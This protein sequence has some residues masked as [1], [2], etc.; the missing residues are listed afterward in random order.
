MDQMTVVV[1]ADP[2]PGW[3]VVAAAVAGVL[4]LIG[5]RVGKRWER[6]SSKRD[7]FRDHRR[8]AYSEFL[9]HTLALMQVAN[10]IGRGSK[11]GETELRRA[12]IMD[13]LKLLDQGR[14]VIGI[15]GEKS[16]AELAERLFEAAGAVR[17]MRVA[18]GFYAELM[19]TPEG[20]AIQAAVD[21]FKQEARRVLES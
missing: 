12:A 4:A 1:A 21:H 16:M 8:V 18:E 9:Q 5:V 19:G 10:L 6:D 11:A 13:E 3:P 14:A 20:E 7:W 2:W 17:D 15:L